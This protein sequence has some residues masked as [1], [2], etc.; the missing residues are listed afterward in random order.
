MRRLSSQ[1]AAVVRCLVE[2]G[3]GSPRT[4]RQIHT[5]VKEHAGLDLAPGVL[6]NI[7]DA[8]ERRGWIDITPVPRSERDDGTNKRRGPRFEQAYLLVDDATSQVAD[9]LARVPA[10]N[11]ADAPSSSVRPSSA[12][13]PAAVVRRLVRG[14]R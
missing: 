7:L 14:V 4:A 9:E 2:A 8:N 11:E 10:P 13:L 3:V 6:Y 12:F 5:W 1:S